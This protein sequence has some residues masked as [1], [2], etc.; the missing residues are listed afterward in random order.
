LFFAGVW[1]FALGSGR[2]RGRWFP[3]SWTL[4][5]LLHGLYEHIVF[6]RGPGML[7]A[8]VPLLLAMA[9]VSW[10][11]L[12]DVAPPPDSRAASSR[13]TIIPSLPDPPSIGAVRRALSRSDR[14]L[15]VHWIAIGTFVTIGVMIV[16]L[17]LAVF[18]GHRVGIDFA[19]ADEGDV[20]STG[21]LML[22][23]VA[24]LAAFPAAGYLVA[25]ASAATSVLEPALGAGLAIAAVVFLISMASPVSVVFALAAA[26]VA[27]A[28]ACGG[29][30]FGLAR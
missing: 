20:R 17:T 4:A 14:A 6:G 29:A 13:G 18:V 28:L 2:A 24:F 27:F 30:W 10:V 9:L 7:I 23:G 15:M 25:K 16:A 19:V 21:P 5:T 8:I 11:A 3:A 22:L 26:P 1:G 12:R